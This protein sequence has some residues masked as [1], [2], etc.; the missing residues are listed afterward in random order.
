MAVCVGWK[1]RVEC[2]FPPWVYLMPDY[3]RPARHNWDAVLDVPIS[4][5][6]VGG[7]PSLR[8]KKSTG[9][10]DKR[11]AVF[12]ASQWV[13]AW[14]MQ[15]ESV[16]KN[17]TSYLATAMQHREEMQKLKD[18]E[19]RESF[20][21]VLLD[22]AEAI[23]KEQGISKGKEYFNLVT[24]KSTLTSVYFEPWKAQL[25]LK[26]K[27]IDRMAK[28]V[29]WFLE[30]FKTVESITPEA[31]INWLDKLEEEGDTYSS[32]KRQ[33]GS[34]RSLWQYLGRKKVVSQAL[35][36]FKSVMSSPPTSPKSYIPFTPAEVVKLWNE[37]KY[38]KEDGELAD[39]IAFGA[40]SGG[41]I[42]ELCSVKLSD[43]TDSSFKIVE[44]KTKAGVREVPIH[45]TIAPLIERLKRDSKD[46]YLIAG[47]TSSKYGKRANSIGKRFG[48]LKTSLGFGE[49]HVFHS[50]RKTVVTQLENAGVSENLAADIVG[51]DKPRI[52]YGLYSGGATMEIKR[53]ALERIAYGFPELS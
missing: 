51:H 18:A 9:T 36:P 26:E 32:R 15:I 38:V 8:F 46:G 49:R 4:L 40:F 17:D 42:E 14:K 28:D 21:H 10:S 25:N 48:H 23:A 29:E 35:D 39:L 44:A 19:E 53:A 13:A 45:S 37:A 5:R 6:G 11:R 47:L 43:V 12:I 30:H 41:R 16:R 27:T 50:I 1:R 20:E 24:G 31:V 2:C 7:L 34:A 33:L 3:I 22:Q 52:T